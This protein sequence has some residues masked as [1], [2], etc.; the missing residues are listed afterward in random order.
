MAK[1][2][3]VCI[4]SWTWTISIP[5]W[6]PFS[7]FF[8]FPLQRLCSKRSGVVWSVVVHSLSSFVIIPIP[9]NAGVSMQQLCT[10]F[11]V[12][13]EKCSMHSYSDGRLQQE[14]PKLVD[15]VWYAGALEM[16]R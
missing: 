8:G 1:Q 4:E 5:N 2:K 16:Y 9:D 12:L 3:S 6:I 7:F 14:H 15:I 11:C 13:S 10:A